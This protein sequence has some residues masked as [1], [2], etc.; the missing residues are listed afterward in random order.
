[1]PVIEAKEERFVL[2]KKRNFS[3]IRGIKFGI[4]RPGGIG[5][6]VIGLYF[7]KEARN[8]S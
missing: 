7:D 8:S 5:G 2:H 4:G 6:I 3:N 1:M